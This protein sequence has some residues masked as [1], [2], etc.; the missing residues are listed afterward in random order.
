MGASQSRQTRPTHATT[1]SPSPTHTAARQTVDTTAEAAHFLIDKAADK[2][3]QTK[4]KVDETKEEA[5]RRA[6]EVKQA[7]QHKK[8]QVEEAASDI[9][10]RA[11]SVK[12]EFKH[13]AEQ[14]AEQARQAVQDTQQ[15]LLER[16]QEQQAGPQL[17]SVWQRMKD[18]VQQRYDVQYRCPTMDELRCT[19]DEQLR[20][21]P[22]PLHRLVVKS[23][24]LL[25][26]C[27]WRH[28]VSPSL[29]LLI[30]STAERGDTLLGQLAYSDNKAGVLGELA[31]TQPKWLKEVHGE[32]TL[33]VPTLDWRTTRVVSDNVW[34]TD[35]GALRTRSS[36]RLGEYSSV[37]HMQSPI[38]AFTF[39]WDYR[40][41]FHS[42]SSGLSA[43]LYHDPLTS[44]AVTTSVSA[45]SEPF[46]NSTPAGRK[47]VPDLLS[48]MVHYAQP[49]YMAD[50]QAAYHPASGQL[51]TYAAR[52]L[53]R[54]TPVGVYPHCKVGVMLSDRAVSTVRDT[55]SFGDTVRLEEVLGSG[56]VDAAC[57]QQPV[58]SSCV[59]YSPSGTVDWKCHVASSGQVGVMMQ[60]QLA[61]TI[62]VE[63]SMVGNVITKDKAA[64]GVG[65]TLG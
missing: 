31:A 60:R 46:N 32:A 24:N 18:N 5:K 13:E 30:V 48:A 54:S 9:K 49:Q 27:P 15:R 63:V 6:E 64:V 26:D 14:K 7:M 43:T 29:E 65:V 40:K 20:F 35:T 19:Y 10:Q 39:R 62:A 23:P 4:L 1:T 28:G 55:T 56:S 21:S 42:V 37:T 41:H 33:A 44:T 58:L 8:L 57:Y 53:F 51:H 59:V 16:P 3:E 47:P 36:A 25:D 52:A 11:E 50:V 61:P 17:K 12:E 22:L 45:T 34:T 38:A 2:A